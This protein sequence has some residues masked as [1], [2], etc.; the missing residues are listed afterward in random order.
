MI[1]RFF[2]L[3]GWHERQGYKSASDELRGSWQR[4]ECRERK[5]KR[6]VRCILAQW[7]TSDN[8]TRAQKRCSRSSHLKRR[9]D[10]FGVLLVYLFSLRGG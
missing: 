8:G 5:I 4:S 6:F 3:A 7:M 2:V 10:A 9:F 1:L